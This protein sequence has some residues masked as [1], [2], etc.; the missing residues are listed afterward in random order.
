M[1]IDEWKKLLFVGCCRRCFFKNFWD[2]CE[3]CGQ[4]NCNRGV[5]TDKVVRDPLLQSELERDGHLHFDLGEE[6]NSGM[7][8]PLKR[9]LALSKINLRMIDNLQY[10]WFNTNLFSSWYTTWTNFSLKILLSDLN[11]TMLEY[12][13][14]IMNPKR[15][16]SNQF[17]K[18]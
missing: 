6:A 18:K 16:Y 7:A 17:F 3:G 13:P 2:K 11:N 8:C 4:H 5:K 9:Q 1:G 15:E 14:Y 12:F 10:K